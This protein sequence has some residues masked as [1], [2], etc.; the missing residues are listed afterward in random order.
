MSNELLKYQWRNERFNVG[1]L[2]EQK[3]QDGP[4][5]DWSRSWALGLSRLIITM[6]QQAAKLWIFYLKIQGEI[7]NYYNFLNFLLLASRT[8]MT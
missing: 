5:S 7:I 4:N 3:W 2:D 6:D 1:L 8:L